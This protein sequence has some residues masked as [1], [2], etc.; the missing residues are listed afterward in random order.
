MSKFTISDHFDAG[1]IT[2]VKADDPLDIQLEI[3]QDNASE[4]LQWFHFSLEGEIGETFKFRLINAGQSSYNKGWDGYN[5]CTSW[6]RQDWFRTPS[7]YENGE[8]TFEITLTQ[9]TVYFSYF[10]PYSHERHLDLLA[11]AQNDVRCTAETLGNTVDGRS[12]TMLKLST[13]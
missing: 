4:F 13:T 1:N 11:W 10:T 5:V 2:I 6:D 3:P 7:S 8:L 12:M 9:S